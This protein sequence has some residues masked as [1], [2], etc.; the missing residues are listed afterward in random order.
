MYRSA[1]LLRHGYA[2]RHVSGE[3]LDFP[4]VLETIYVTCAPPGYARAG[5]V[6]RR[7]CA[8]AHVRHVACANKYVRRR[9]CADAHVRHMGCNNNNNNNNN[10]HHNNPPTHKRSSVLDLLNILPFASHMMTA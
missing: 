10:N 9:V 8:S 1:A 2:R 3:T 4:N 6:R 7:V 5:I